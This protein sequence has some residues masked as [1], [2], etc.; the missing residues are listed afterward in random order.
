MSIA[1]WDVGQVVVVM[2]DEPMLSDPDD[3]VDNLAATL[4][5]FVVTTLVV[6]I[7]NNIVN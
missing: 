1:A 2:L 7:P 6:A 4:V 5:A 3:S